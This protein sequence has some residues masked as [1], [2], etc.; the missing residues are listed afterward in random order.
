MQPQ[1]ANPLEILPDNRGWYWPLLVV[2]LLA[3]PICANFYLMARAN[4][5]PSFV[6]E[7]DYYRK[8]VAWDGQMAQD[9]ANLA[10]GWLAQIV[11]ARPFEVDVQLLD[12]EGKPLENAA[13]TAQ[14]LANARAGDV[15]PVRVTPLGQ[16][17]FTLV[18]P[19]RFVGLYELRLTVKHGTDLFTTQLRQD[20]AAK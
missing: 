15:R 6:I 18:I 19:Q 8:A 13:L 1:V 16:G 5:D 4:G 3:I 11:Q 12:K 17:K 9:K 20:L 2:C 14:S 7:N 10:L